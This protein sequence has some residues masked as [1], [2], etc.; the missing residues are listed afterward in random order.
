MRQ[1]LITT[2]A[3][4]AMLSYGQTAGTPAANSNQGHVRLF[5]VPVGGKYGYIDK[6]GKLA[7]APQFYEADDFSEG[8]AAVE[9]DDSW[10]YIDK[11]GKVVITPQFDDAFGFSGGL[12]WVSISGKGKR[13]Y[14]DKTGKFVWQPSNPENAS[15]GR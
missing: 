10:G 13:G 3:L 11:T 4:L 2:L 12:A 14:I 9:I 1:V 15:G 8:L 6:T 7:I 5:T